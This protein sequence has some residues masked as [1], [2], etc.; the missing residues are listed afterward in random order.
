MDSCIATIGSG[1]DT[2]RSR[3]HL[4]N[5]NHIGKLLHRHP[6]ILRNNLSLNQGYHGIAT[7]ESEDAY[8][9]E[10]DEKLKKYHHYVLSY[11]LFYLF[12]FFPFYLYSVGWI[13]C[14]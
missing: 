11:L 3:C 1:V 10:Y 13:N 9:N 14:P 8:L 7:S 4:R 5:G 12:T 6:M 2:D